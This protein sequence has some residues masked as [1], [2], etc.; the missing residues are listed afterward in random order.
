MEPGPEDQTNSGAGPAEP[1]PEITEPEE[2]VPLPPVN[3]TGVIWNS[4]RPQ[5]IINDHIVNVGDTI[6]GIKITEINKTSIEGLFSGRTVTIQ[7]Q[8]S[9]L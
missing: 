3:V 7:T 2:I 8:R 9:Q 4:D 5:A 1:L 6:S